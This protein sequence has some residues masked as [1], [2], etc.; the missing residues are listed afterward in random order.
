MA[1]PGPMPLP[2]DDVGWVYLEGS[3]LEGTALPWKVH[4]QK[5]H[6]QKV[7]PRRYTPKGTPLVLT[8]SGGYQNEWMHPTGMLSCLKSLHFLHSQPVGTQT[9]WT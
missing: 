2:G 1:I 4:P 6:P 7:H 5:V 9:F 8:S 3:P